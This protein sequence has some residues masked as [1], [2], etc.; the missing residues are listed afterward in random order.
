MDNR[1]VLYSFA[2]VDGISRPFIVWDITEE[3]N[4][5]YKDSFYRTI[6]GEKTHMVFVRNR[7]NTKF[8]RRN[9][10]RVFPSSSQQ[11][12][13]HESELH[14]AAKAIILKNW[15]LYFIHI[16]KEVKCPAC[17][18]C[19]DF[20]EGSCVYYS[21]DGD[22]GFKL[23]D[24]FKE[25]PVKEKANCT[26]QFIPDVLFRNSHDEEFWIEI[27]D[28]NKV[29]S[30]KVWHGIPILEIDIKDDS[31]IEWL[32]RHRNFYDGG[33]SHFYN[34]WALH[35]IKTQY[36]HKLSSKYEEIQTLYWKG[37]I[38]LGMDDAWP[39]NKHR[40]ESIQSVFENDRDYF[41]W[42]FQQEHLGLRER[43]SR[44]CKKSLGLE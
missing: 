16:P 12:G 9:P 2:F 40:G 27:N 14:R 29:R 32:Y 11:G 3:E 31:D 23:S 5:R 4:R 25:Q 22:R 21:N 8:F 41:Y 36:C 7:Y 10:N 43:L 28:T 35:D 17:Y 26:G 19:A 44:N 42:C 20:D 13:G 24:M 39:F 30:K 1:D 38:G 37:D 34:M 18:M 6:D 15:K 33:K